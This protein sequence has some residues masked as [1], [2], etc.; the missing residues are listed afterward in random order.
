MYQRERMRNSYKR[1]PRFIT[2]GNI[3]TIDHVG[4]AMNH[5]L[6]LLKKQTINKKKTCEKR[7]IS[8]EFELFKELHTEKVQAM[9]LKSFIFFLKSKSWI[10]LFEQRIYLLLHCDRYGI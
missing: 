5:F 1:C 2:I 8:L 4:E 6:K 3:I 9:Q 10:L 7:E